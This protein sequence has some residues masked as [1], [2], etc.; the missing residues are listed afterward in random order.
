VP[1]DEHQVLEIKRDGDTILID[2]D[3]FVQHDMLGRPKQPTVMS[4]DNGRLSIATGLGNAPVGLSADNEF[5]HVADQ[6]FRR[7]SPQ[8]LAAI[9]AKIAAEKQ[10]AEQ[11]R[12]RCGQLEAEYKMP[13]SAEHTK[14]SDWSAVFAQREAVRKSY[15]EKQNAIPGCHVVGW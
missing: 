4:Q 6:K 15:M 8:G 14:R 7:S 2:D 5:L 10:T 1:A 11:N 3:V 13:E 12:A 9:R